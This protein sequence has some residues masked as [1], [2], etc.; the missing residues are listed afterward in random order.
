MEILKLCNQLEVLIRPPSP[1]LSDQQ[2]Q[3]DA[4]LLS[5]PSLK[6]LE[7]NYNSDAELSGGI[8][9]LGATLQGAPNLHYLVIGNVPRYGLMMDFRQIALPFLETLAI[10]S[11]NGQLLHQIAN[12]WSLPSLSHLVL[13][14]VSVP[15]V[16]GLWETYGGQIQSLE[17]G[18][19]ASFL[20]RD[21]ITSALNGCPRLE[22][23][24]YHLFF[25]LPPIL[26]EPQE[27]IHTVGLHSA[28]NMMFS[29][30]ASFDLV[31]KHLDVLATY[32]S[33][34]RAIRLSGDWSQILGDPRLVP[35]Y[36]KLRQRGCELVVCS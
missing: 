22:E 7:W 31:Q 20:V 4:D 23:L 34:L 30:E 14:A 26:H 17:L 27:S 6:R 21:V 11:L 19:H 5:L 18:R 36:V 16:S 13:S 12:R 35:I 1:P 25:S 24:N 8:N 15:D 10:S 29:D 3:F 28:P 33:S 2:F 9:S 32:F